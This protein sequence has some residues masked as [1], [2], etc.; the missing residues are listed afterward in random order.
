MT[1]IFPLIFGGVH[2]MSVGSVAGI[3]CHRAEQGK[4]SGVIWIDAHAI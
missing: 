4:T 3:A 2:S 1:D